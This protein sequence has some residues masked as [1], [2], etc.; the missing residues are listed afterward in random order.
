MLW[1]LLLLSISAQPPAPAAAPA[2]TFSAPAAIVQ[3]DTGKL[4]GDITE[5]AWSPDGTQIYLQTAKAD[6][7]GNLLNRHYLVTLDGKKP[8]KIDAEPDWAAQYWRW[9]S[10]PGSPGS[11][12][13]KITVDSEE[14][15]YQGVATPMG[16][17]LE[18]GG[19]DTGARGPSMEEMA[20]AARTRQ[21]AHAIRLRVRSHV[22]GEW[23]NEPVRPGLTFGWAPASVGV[24]SFVDQTKGNSL[25]ILNEAGEVRMVDGTKGAL[26]PAWS[27]DGGRLAFLRRD[28]KKK[29]TLELITV[30]S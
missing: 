12:D 29:F 26:L 6:R 8:L 3:L 19:V 16:G 1:L 23:V 13:F 17:S 25:A 24:L 10:A 2:L 14:K 28:G 5:L 27:D 30:G 4:D 9:K 15:T 22:I 7:F 21:S 11:G 18:T 20:A